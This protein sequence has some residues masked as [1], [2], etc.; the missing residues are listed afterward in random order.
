MY[1]RCIKVQHKLINIQFRD[2]IQRSKRN[3]V[4]CGLAHRTVSGAPG[5]YR[6]QAATLGF[7]QARSAIIHRTVRRATGLSGEPAG[8]GYLRATVDYKST[9]EGNSAAAEVR[10]AKSEG[11]GLSGVAPDCPM[12]Q[13]DKAPTVDFAPNPNNWVTWRRTGQPTVPVRWRTGLSGAPIDSSL[14][15]GYFGG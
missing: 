9:D 13:G 12:P 8:N 11:T 2:P 10:A 7:S 3:Q 1:Y 6:V 15:N 4:C 5:L 14:P